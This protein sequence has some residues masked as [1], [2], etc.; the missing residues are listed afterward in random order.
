MVSYLQNG[1]WRG[2]HNAEWPKYLA[3]G[4][5]DWSELAGRELYNHSNDPE[6]NRNVEAEPASVPPRLAIT[7]S[8]FTSSW[9]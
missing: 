7:E 6:E 5:A 3:V 4:K 1:P 2:T 8:G 9:K